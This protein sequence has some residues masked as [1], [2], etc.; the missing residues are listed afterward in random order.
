MRLIL[1]VMG[2]DHSIP[3]A[4]EHDRIFFGSFSETVAHLTEDQVMLLH[5]WAWMEHD[6]TDSWFH[7]V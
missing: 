7:W 3:V 2:E 5:H 1:E 4:V 6:D